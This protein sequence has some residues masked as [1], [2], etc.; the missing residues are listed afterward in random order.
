MVRAWI[1]DGDLQV[2]LKVGFW[3]DRDMN[4]PDA[5]GLLLSDVIRH[6]AHAHEQE[7]GR[8]PRETT[9]AVREAIERGLSKP[10]SVTGHFPRKPTATKPADAADRRGR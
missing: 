7:Y 1:V 6:I 2:A 9:L 8:D 4:E 5:W 3:A 10:A